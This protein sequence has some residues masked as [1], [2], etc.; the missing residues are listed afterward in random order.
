VP[1]S[2][3]VKPK[4]APPRRFKKTR[5]DDPSASWVEAAKESDLFKFEKHRQHMFQS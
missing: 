4:P 3:L 5:R 2:K 1:T